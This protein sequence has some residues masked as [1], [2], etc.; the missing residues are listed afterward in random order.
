MILLFLFPVL[1]L[2]QPVCYQYTVNKDTVQEYFYELNFN[3]KNDYVCVS[4]DSFEYWY[5]VNRVR[6]KKK[7][8]VYKINGYTLY[9]MNDRIIQK[10]SRIKKNI[11][12]FCYD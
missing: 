12:F 2:G 8:S 3:F 6:H 7:K 11:Y 4:T 10:Y 1:L 9:K 5:K